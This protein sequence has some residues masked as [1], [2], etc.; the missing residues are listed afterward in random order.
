VREDWEEHL[1]RKPSSC[2]PFLEGNLAGDDDEQSICRH[3]QPNSLAALTVSNDSEELLPISSRL[4]RT[5]L[6]IR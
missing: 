2:T 3:R 4:E 5:S 1:P 6:L